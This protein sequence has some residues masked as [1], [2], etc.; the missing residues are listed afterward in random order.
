MTA[1]QAR[2]IG[3]ALDA[4]REIE[5]AAR[6]LSYHS[7]NSGEAR[8][9]CRVEMAAGTAADAIGDYLII[10]NTYGTPEAQQLS[11]ALLFPAGRGTTEDDGD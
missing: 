5:K 4:L 10:V 7:N 1:A 6:S 9:A 8:E 2:R 11:E 3:F